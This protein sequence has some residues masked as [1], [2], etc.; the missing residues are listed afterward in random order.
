MEYI[1]VID[2]EDEMKLNFWDQICI[3][4][5]HCIINWCTLNGACTFNMPE[6]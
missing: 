6:Y 2:N 1:N 3:M 5:G 4:N